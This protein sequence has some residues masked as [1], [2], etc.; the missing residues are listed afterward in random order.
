MTEQTIAQIAGAW[1]PNPNDRRS[2]A[3]EERAAALAWERGG[4]T[5]PLSSYDLDRAEEEITGE[6]NL[7]A[8]NARLRS[9]KSV[10]PLPKGASLFAV[11]CQTGA[12]FYVNHAD[13]WQ[14]MPNPIRAHL[15][16]EGH[17]HDSE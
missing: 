17:D 2:P 4:Q 8:E 12:W 10:P 16:S 7:R 6:V 9:R 3:V 1:E 15:L 5:T 11:N 13:T 14:G